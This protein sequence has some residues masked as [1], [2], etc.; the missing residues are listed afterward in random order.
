MKSKFLIQ[1]R[2]QGIGFRYWVRRQFGKFNIKGEVWN[3]EDGTVGVECIGE[4]N[5]MEK[6]VKKLNE[7]PPL[8]RVDKVDIL[9]SNEDKAA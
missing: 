6:M 1:G 4:E 3:N 5:E 7:G 9:K 2:V 8:A